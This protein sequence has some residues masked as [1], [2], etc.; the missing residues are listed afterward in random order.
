LPY[1]T[2]LRPGGFATATLRSGTT[3]APILP[4]SAILSDANG[5]YV[6]VVGTDNKVERRAIAIGDVTA[7]GIAVLKGLS[8][9]ERVVLRAGGFL[10]PGDKVKPAVDRSAIAGAVARTK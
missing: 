10:N 2:A 6:Y 3:T 7:A 4:E 9:N 8:G 1:D 5:A